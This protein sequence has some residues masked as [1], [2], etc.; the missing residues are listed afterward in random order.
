MRAAFIAF[1]ALLPMLPVVTAS[2]QEPAAPPALAEQVAA[3][4][5][6]FK[7][8]VVLYAKNLRHGGAFQIGADTRVRTASTI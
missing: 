3:L 8:T 5:K 4:T 7:G 6:D 1:L 2:A